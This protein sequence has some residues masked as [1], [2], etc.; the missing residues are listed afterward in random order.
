MKQIK[1]DG[2]AIVH[3]KKTETDRAR[4]RAA[5]V[6]EQQIER[7]I[8]ILYRLVVTAAVLMVMAGA[9]VID[10]APTLS[11]EVTGMVM[12]VGGVFVIVVGAT[13]FGEEEK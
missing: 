3:D 10:A 5:Q 11:R 12:M 8:Q 2:V 7:L 1:Y 9:G 6:R 13:L 4:R